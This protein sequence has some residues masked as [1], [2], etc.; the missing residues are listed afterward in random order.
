MTTESAQLTKTAT[1][2]VANWLIPIVSAGVAWVAGQAVV[3]APALADLV[4]TVNQEAVANF[5]VGLIAAVLI[6]AWNAWTNRKLKAGVE[7]AQVIL[8][9]AVPQPVTKDGVAG[10]KFLKALTDLALSSLNKSASKT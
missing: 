9:N 5:I 6:G 4:S 2:T 8:D 3:K 10:P 7:A 1:S